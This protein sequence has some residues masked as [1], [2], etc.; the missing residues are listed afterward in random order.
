MQEHSAMVVCGSCKREG[1]PVFD[2]VGH[3]LC[4]WCNADLPTTPTLTTTVVTVSYPTREDVLRL[5]QKLDALIKALKAHGVGAW[6]E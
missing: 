6:G 2:G 4:Y 3:A 5:E 1:I